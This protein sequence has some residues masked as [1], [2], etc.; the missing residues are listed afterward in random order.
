MKRVAVLAVGGVLAAILLAWVTGLGAWPGWVGVA[1]TIVVFVLVLASGWSAWSE[2]PPVVARDFT[3]A[4]PPAAP[5][6]ELS[7]DQVRV[8]SSDPDYRFLLS[9]VVCWRPRP[10]TGRPLP[11]DPADVAKRE[12]IARTS[13]ITSAGDPAEYDLVQH[14]VDSALAAPTPDRT[15]VIDVWAHS[16]T[17]A[18]TEE[19]LQR[20]S[21]LATVR[22]DEQVWEHSRKYRRNVQR[23]LRDE[24]L[25]DPGSGVV[26][27]LAKDPDRIKDAVDVIGAF[28][29]LSAAANNRVVD[30]AF[31]HLVGTGRATPVAESEPL[32]RDALDDA[33]DGVRTL[34]ST[35]L[36]SDSGP[37]RGYFAYRLAEMVARFGG[38]DLADRI[39]A[40][41]GVTDLADDPVEPEGN[42]ASPSVGPE[43]LSAPLFEPL[44]PP[45]EGP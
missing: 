29:Q 20:Q 28:A 41:Y 27:Y 1:F 14:Q 10:N 13:Q 17:L 12:V 36:P 9:A 24:V 23:Y 30:A 16:V 22:K 35:L 33:A 38:S 45:R 42:G 39:R 44:R 3:L 25:G 4:S 40:D 7:I 26:W 15:G 8:S 43:V 34:V 37:E 2:Q 21:Q 32:P 6:P 18:L 11:A 19:D 5:R 31:E